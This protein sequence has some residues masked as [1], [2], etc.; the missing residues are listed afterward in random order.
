MTSCSLQGIFVEIM[1]QALSKESALFSLLKNRLDTVSLR[2]A[3]D[4]HD[5]AIC[6]RHSS[7]RFAFTRPTPFFHAERARP[8]KESFDAH[9][10]TICRTHSVV[11]RPCCSTRLCSRSRAVQRRPNPLSAHQM[12]PSA[13]YGKLLSNMEKEFVDAAEA[14]PEDKFNFAPADAGRFQGRTSLRR[15]R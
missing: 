14:M 9:P 2:S 1:R 12:T 7:A 8:R 3:T 6:T 4:S 10:L 13:T 5:S 15:R 11:L